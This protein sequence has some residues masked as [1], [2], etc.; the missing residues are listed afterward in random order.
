MNGMGMLNY[1]AINFFYNLLISLLTNLVFYIFGYIYL[2]NAFFQQVGL[3]IIFTVFFGWILSQIGLAMF[4]QVFLSAS[5]AANII[6][7]LVAIWTNLIGATLSIALFQYPRE[8]PLSFAIWPTFSFNRLFYLLF[9]NC[10]MDQCPKTLSNLSPEMWQ[11][12][13]VLYVSFFI[14]SLAGMYLYEVIPQ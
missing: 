3:S 8:L 6:G 5:R 11:C 13:T 14:F 1:W 10:S 2:E 9:T 7:Y 4:L 12:I